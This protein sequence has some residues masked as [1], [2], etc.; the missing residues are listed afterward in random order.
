MKKIALH[1]QILIGMIIGGILGFSFNAFG[2]EITWLNTLCGFIGDLFIRGLRFVA[3]PIVLFSLIVGAGGLGDIKKLGSI[4]LKTFLLYLCTTAV[5]ISIGLLLANLLQPGASLPADLQA[6]LIAEGGAGATQKMEAAQAPNFLDTL[7]NIIPINPFAALA[8]GKMLQ[9]VFF[10]LIIGM[11]IN[12]LPKEKGESILRVSDA[13]SE[14]FIKFVQ[15]FMY[16]APVAVA[17][18]LFKVCASLG[19]EVLSVLLLYCIVVLLGLLL[20][21]FGVYLLLVK[22]FSAI[23]LAQFYRGIAPAQLLAFSSASSAATMPLTLQCVQKELNVSEEVSSFVIPLG[24]TVNMDGTALY[25]GVAAIFIAQLYGMDLSLSD[26]V[27]IVLTAT[28]ASIGTAGVPGVGMI[29]LVIVLQSIGMSPE[30]MAGGLAIIFGVDRLL[31]MARTVCNVTGDCTVAAVVAQS[32]SSDA[33][34]TA[35]SET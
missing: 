1:W 35:P 29:M 14:I 7:L 16:T 9:I 34:S 12:L 27:T 26:Q 32:I 13:L 30:N 19:L 10:S 21:I 31:D 25:Q 8:E 4:G 22:Q 3:V 5:A 2:I 24:A 33:G 20:M 15:I 11:G 18:L 28:L 23:P 17:A 6:K